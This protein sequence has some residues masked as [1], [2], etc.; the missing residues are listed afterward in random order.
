MTIV[1]ISFGCPAI[2]LGRWPLMS[3]FLHVRNV[4]DMVRIEASLFFGCAECW[5][6]SNHFPTQ[7]RP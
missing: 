5:H 3:A 6:A 7:A 4:R 2:C 1:G